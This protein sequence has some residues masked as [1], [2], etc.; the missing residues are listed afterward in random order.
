MNDADLRLID[1]GGQGMLAWTL[2]FLSGGMAGH[3]WGFALW[4]YVQQI[5][6]VCNFLLPE[7][8]LDPT[9]KEKTITSVFSRRR[10]GKAGQDDKMH[11]TN[12]KCTDDVAVARPV[13]N[14]EEC[15]T[16][17]AAVD[18]KKGS[19]VHK[20][21]SEDN[22]DITIAL[23][24]TS[25]RKKKAI[26]RAKN[27][28]DSAVLHTEGKGDEGSNDGGN[29]TSSSQVVLYDPRVEGCEVDTSLKETVERRTKRSLPSKDSEKEV[30]PA[31]RRR[32]SKNFLPSKDSEAPSNK[33]NLMSQM[34]IQT[35]IDAAKQLERIPKLIKSVRDTGFG[36]FIDTKIKGSI[37]RKCMSFI[38]KNIDIPTMTVTFSEEKKIVINRYAIHHLYGIPNGHLSAPRPNEISEVLP[39]LKQELGFKSDEDITAKKLVV[40]LTSMV[41]GHVYSKAEINTNLALKLFYLILLNKGNL[42][43][44]SQMLDRSIPG[45]NDHRKIENLK[46][47]TASLL[48]MFELFGDEQKYLLDGHRI[49][50]RSSE[51]N[52]LTSI[53]AAKKAHQTVELD[54]GKAT[55][56]QHAKIVEEG[57]KDKSIIMPKKKKKKRKD[58]NKTGI[59]GDQQLEETHPDPEQHAGSLPD[60]SES[61][62]ESNKKLAIQMSCKKDAEADRPELV[63]SAATITGMSTDKLAESLDPKDAETS[64]VN[65]EADAPDVE[66]SAAT[67]SEKSADMLAESPDRNDQNI[68]S[69]SA[70]NTEEVQ[71]PKDY[72]QGEQIK[73]PCFEEGDEECPVGHYFVM[74]VN[75]KNKWF[76]LLDSL[77]GEGAEQHFVNTA[78]VFKEIWK[79]AYR[80]SNGE[81]SPG[82]LDD[83]SYEKPKVIPLQGQTLNCGIYMIM[84]LMFWNGKSLYYIRLGDILYIRKRLLY[85]VLLWENLEV[86]LDLIETI[87]KDK[88][89]KIT[90]GQYNLVRKSTS[91]KPTMTIIVSLPDVNIPE[92]REIDDGKENYPEE[93]EYVLIGSQEDYGMECLKGRGRAEET[94]KNGEEDKET[95]KNSEEDK[96][97][98]VAR[99]NEENNIEYLRTREA[100]VDD[101][102]RLLQVLFTPANINSS[103]P[104]YKIEKDMY[105]SL[106]G[107]QSLETPPKVSKSNYVDVEHK[108]NLDKRKRDIV[109]PSNV[110]STK[111]PRAIA[112]KFCEPVAKHRQKKFK[113]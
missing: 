68:K 15:A 89:K 104:G 71:N 25:G 67:V 35:I 18:N 4:I 91:V 49:D 30:V 70:T 17:L 5:D 19:Q 84:F 16:S 14:A 96:K 48:T 32:V 12:T 27:S 46:V 43:T 7:A 51:T 81:L 52:Q 101:P 24:K 31:K 86:N 106:T 78:D 13:K 55:C 107:S 110:T 34:S 79:E 53:P 54:V 3:G 109:T 92:P 42:Q 39:E 45:D 75:L 64:N 90:P 80:Q 93:Q 98:V 37:N 47:Q 112:R 58:S 9:R 40:M 62:Q 85:L 88:L 76:E 22:R 33:D 36:P 72:M 77:G 57:C 100:K 1:L 63:T 8:G 82:N 111:R 59:I 99:N 60:I 10:K 38:L 21:L 26:K 23:P 94:T 6:C 29:P 87:D 97:F 83:F 95:T 66:T 56:E 113:H 102:S 2:P 28:T 73:I 105:Y 103:P 74:S 61:I 69:A 50:G 20:S 108:T 41:G 65:A 11:N 44:T